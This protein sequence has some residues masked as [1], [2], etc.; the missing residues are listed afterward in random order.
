MQEMLYPTSYILGKGLGPQCALV[1]D[2]RFSG[3][4]SGLA[5]GHVSPEAAAGGVIGLVEDGDVISID[6]PTRSIHLE[7]DDDELAR[8][9]A[10]RDAA[11][12]APAARQRPVSA[13]LKAYAALA[14]SADR[15]A[16]RNLQGDPK[17]APAPAP[18][19]TGPE[20]STTPVTLGRKSTS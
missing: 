9:R 10:A 4:T 16:A 5:I 6:I 1:T 8:R 17:P 14:M 20:P 11:G 3:G 12:W 18:A 13:A 15:G 19:A 2:G 7:V